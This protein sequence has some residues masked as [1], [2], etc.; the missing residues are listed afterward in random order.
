MAQVLASW[1]LRK[2]CK[3]PAGFQH[4]LFDFGERLEAL[5]PCGC[6][7]LGH[8]NQLPLQILHSNFTAQHQNIG[9]AFNQLVEF[10]MIEEEAN[11]QI[12]GDEQAGTADD[13]TQAAVASPT[14][15]VLHVV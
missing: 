3:C 11:D 13:S 1:L 6:F 8:G 10:T 5:L 4:A 15:V 7:E 2:K 9:S 14:E 12:V